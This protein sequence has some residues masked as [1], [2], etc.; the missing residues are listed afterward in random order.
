MS[1]DL[2]D[3]FEAARVR[4]DTRLDV[5]GAGLR[6]A[7]EIESLIAAVDLVGA[8][9][10]FSWV[11]SFAQ[12]PQE[13][14]GAVGISEMGPK[15]VLAVISVAFFIGCMFVDPIVVILILVGYGAVRGDFAAAA[16]FLFTPDFSKIGPGTVLAAVSQAFFSIGVAMAGMMT[17][18]SYLPRSINLTQSVLIIVVADTMVAILAGLVIFPAVFNNGLD[19]AAGAGLIFQTLPVAFALIAVRL[20]VGSA[21][22]RTGRAGI[23]TGMAGAA[24]SPDRRI[25]RQRQI[26][27]QQ[28][29][30][31]FRQRLV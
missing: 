7:R 16:R 30:D 23:D 29:L 6:S 2:L 17:Y 3:R 20:W 15:G 9:A 31:L 11:I 22:K 12:I 19:P 26:G 4:I 1:A 13:L 5:N 24:M 14:L 10:A 28:A 21:D 27:L 18:G 8:G 25:R